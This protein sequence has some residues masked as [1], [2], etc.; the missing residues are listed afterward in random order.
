MTRSRKLVAG[1]TAALSVAGC[2]FLGLFLAGQGLQNAS[3]WASVLSLVTGVAALVV[4]I[5]PTLLRSSAARFV[6]AELDLPEWVVERPREAG[7]AV[8]A[9]LGRRGKTVAITTG[10]HGAG[11]FGKTT[12]AQIVCADRR[13]RNRFPG[14][15]FPIT[16]GRDT[17]GAAAMAAKV[18]DVI[19]LV[20]G[21]E[22]TFTDPELAGSRLGML[23]DSGPQRL[24]LI[25]DVWETEQLAP[26]VTGGR[27]CARLVTTRVP[28]LL[29]PRT[30][31]VLVDQMSV[32]QARKLLMR[33]LSP[34]DPAVAGGLLEVTGRWP[35]LL[36]LVNKILANAAGSG[37]DVRAAAAQ[38][39]E[40]LR[41]AGPAVVDDLLGEDSQTLRVGVP[42][43]RA[44]AVRATIG[45]STSLLSSEDA[46]RFRELGVFAEDE[47]IPF[48]LVARL[49]S[50]TAGF[51]DLR[52][53][54]LCGRLSELA[55]VSTPTGATKASGIVLHDVVRDF[56]RAELGPDA[57]THLNGVLLDATGAD[58]PVSGSASGT[59]GPAKIMWWKLR[60]DDRYMWEHLIEHLVD[61]G[62]EE[63]AG[64]LAGDLRW[65]GARLLNFGPA[66][67]AADLTLIGTPAAAGLR[68][69]L[70]RAAHLLAPT[71]P[72]E[73]VVDVL[74]SRVADTPGWA[75]QVTMLREA[76]SRCRLANRWPLPDMPHSALRRV[77]TGHDSPVDVLAIA[78]DSKWLATGDRA[79]TTRIWDADTGRIRATLTRE[80]GQAVMAMAISPDSSWLVTGG[81]DGIARIWDTVT[82]QEQVALT[83]HHGRV[84]QAVIDQNGTLLATLDEGG[85]AG[86]AR[87]WDT[88]TWQPKLTLTGHRD[89]IASIAIASDGSWL[90]TGGMNGEAQVWDVAT[91]R[92]RAKLPGHRGRVSAVAIAPDGNWL[93]TSD[94][95]SVRIWDATTGQSRASLY[96]EL[97]GT[98]T[99]LMIS[100]DSTW[101][102]AI[103]NG[104]P[105]VWDTAGRAIGTQADSRSPSVRVLAATP[106]GSWLATGGKDGMVRLFDA[107][108][109]TE[110]AS[111][112]GHNRAVTSI[113]VASNGHWIA[114]GDEGGTVRIWD[115]TTSQHR[116]PLPPRRL[117]PTV[118]LAAP[119]GDWLATIG[120]TSVQIWDGRTGLPRVVLPEA[121]GSVRSSRITKVVAAPDGSWLAARDEKRVIRI[122]DTA[123]G[124]KRATIMSIR[125]EA[126]ESITAVAVSPDSSWLATGDSRG[127]VRAWD[128]STG[129]NIGDFQ[130]RP[131]FA[132][133]ARITGISI[134]PDG[135]WLAARQ[136]GNTMVIW[137]K[138]EREVRA[139]I[140]GHSS[141]NAVIAPDSQWLASD[142]RG[143]VR[144]YD[145]STGKLRTTLTSRKRTIRT[146]TI[147][148][149]NSWLATEEQDGPVRT[150]DPATGQERAALRAGHGQVKFVAVSPDRTWLATAEEGYIR[151]WDPASGQQ[152]AALPLQHARATTAAVSPDG[153]WLAATEGQTMLIW[154]P[155]TGKVQALMRA[156]HA[157]S[158]CTWLGPTALAASSWAGLY[159]FDLLES[160]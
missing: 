121:A 74:H 14:G 145:A 83:G 7:Q 46:L 31:A 118:M 59:E 32:E 93:A 130:A 97:R 39:L 33:D 51:D 91:G 86:R 124:Q 150:W 154:D 45:A 26:F 100:P 157:F 23:L 129:K 102:A 17:R 147:A 57:L 152:R 10:L 42:A 109:I 137:D 29:G 151:I 50:V 49:W 123:S 1:V 80:R 43:E 132:N 95:G 52:V 76:E 133:S 99:A 15:I 89:Q 16:I 34:L 19:K 61:A 134:A 55:L 27:Q 143:V 3:L 90:A 146:V 116:A 85:V 5:W 92:L 140:G 62:R 131:T 94:T 75:Q 18:N 47:T 127:F 6:P 11:G 148:P 36:R 21:G 13:V 153:R 78:P 122:W 82:G 77:L 79:G 66:G 87:L 106:D 138:G 115:V 2:V 104:Q 4:P 64:T 72:A 119:D 160:R 144:T 20:S 88:I 68:M 103:D 128:A 71:E 67:P 54:R 24:L 41:M 110:R 139:T 84:T 69:A 44:R 12:L 108:T 135:S 141:E 30:Q 38:L 107:A 40:R 9:L 96:G 98:V 136:L 70:S 120:D 48:G 28:G 25:D 142:S 117:A 156:D 112:A 158:S 58:L 53:T 63:E 56:L 73:A 159:A 114:T 155:I 105:R 126:P 113:A 65:V 149:D 22:A 37:A 60:S 35:L 111:M 125:Y 101:L 8:S 81:T